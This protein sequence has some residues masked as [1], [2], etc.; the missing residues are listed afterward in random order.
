MPK[1]DPRVPP[2]PIDVVLR[3]CAPPP[4][5]APAPPGLA[6]RIT[7]QRTRPHPRTRIASPRRS[8][9]VAL[10]A[11]LAISAAA[12]ASSSIWLA[13]PQLD[14]RVPAA[15]EWQFYPHDPY[16][17]P[18]S[19]P[20]LLRIHPAWVAAANRRDTE[21]LRARGIP[22]ARCGI[23]RRHPLACYQADGRLIAYIDPTPDP[24]PTNVDVRRL[25]S[26]QA[27]AW[28]CA[29]RAADPATD[30][31]ERRPRTSERARC[32]SAADPP[33]SERPGRRR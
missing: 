16:G 22:G 8:L 31:G 7:T 11:F 6:Q 19:G 2:D 24:G 26:A 23:D 29:H 13:R 18:S 5:T 9:A 14:P 25:S 28:L 17:D 15:P 10:A 21:Q 12:A 3:R 30:Y 4:W 27:R 1:P 32:A 33:R 20:V